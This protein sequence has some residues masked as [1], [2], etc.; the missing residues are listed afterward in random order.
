MPAYNNVLFSP[1]APVANVTLRNPVSGG[2]LSDIALLIDSGADVT[3]L[4]KSSLEALGV[5]FNSNSAFELESFDGNVSSSSSVRVDLLWQ[6]KTF[7]GEFLTIDQEIGYLGR[8]ILNFLCLT[9]DG[10]SL[11]WEIR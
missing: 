2:L 5:N 4:P 8:D 7:K 1:P 9:L 10:R 11:Q 6:G 3:L